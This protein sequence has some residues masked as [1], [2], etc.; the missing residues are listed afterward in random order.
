MLFRSKEN[1][2]YFIGRELNR[3]VGEKYKS[4]MLVLNFYVKNKY[5]DWFEKN[6]SNIIKQNS[7]LFFNTNYLLQCNS[8][9]ML[10]WYKYLKE[11]I[12]EEEIKKFNGKLSAELIVIQKNVKEDSLVILENFINLNPIDY[13]ESF[14]KVLFSGTEDKKGIEYWYSV[15]TMRLKDKKI[16]FE[17]LWENKESRDGKVNYEAN[18]DC[19]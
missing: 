15:I 3:L 1:S 6:L 14:R 9:E 19:E 7:F 16:F 11:N 5:E 8:T 18:L 12:S 10:R 17:N 4:Q 2:F 13:Q